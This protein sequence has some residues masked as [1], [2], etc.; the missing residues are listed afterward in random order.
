M[1]VFREV[2]E[3]VVGVVYEWNT[4]PNLNLSCIRAANYSAIPIS[5]PGFASSMCNSA[6]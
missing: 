6:S 4:L 2:G 5:T 3:D 1:A